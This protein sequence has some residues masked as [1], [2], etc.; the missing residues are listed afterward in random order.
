MNIGNLIRCEDFIGYI[1]LAKMYT[2][3]YATDF[4]EKI[5]IK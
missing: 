2:I 5:K 4:R 3:E 1:S